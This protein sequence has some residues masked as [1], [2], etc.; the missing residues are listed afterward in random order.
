MR[1]IEDLLGGV[2]VLASLPPAHRA[3]IAG[4]AHNEVFEPGAQILREGAAADTFYM[5][6][7]GAVALETFVPRRGPLTME[8]LHGGELVGWWWLFPPYRN[9]FDARALDT[10][11]AI[12]FDGACLRGKCDADP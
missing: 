1:T 7:T 10:T 8:T 9:A 5:I 11:H 3:T 4:C 2:P 6:R 12:S